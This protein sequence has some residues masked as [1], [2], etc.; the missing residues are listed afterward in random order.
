[1]LHLIEIKINSNLKENKNIFHPVF[2][3]DQKLCVDGAVG[4]HNIQ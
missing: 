2:F 4:L 3:T 1:M